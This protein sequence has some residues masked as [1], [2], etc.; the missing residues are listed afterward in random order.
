MARVEVVEFYTDERLRSAIVYMIEAAQVIGVSKLGRTKLMK[1]LF[2]AD[3]RSMQELKR[4]ISGT[5]YTYY[6]YGP[7][8]SDVLLA[9]EEMDGYEILEVPRDFATDTEE[10]L[11]YSYSLGE[12][13]RFE[14]QLPEEDR[15]II[16]EVLI[17]YGGL[18]LSALLKHVYGMTRMKDAEPF[19]MILSD[20]R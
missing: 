12:S 18:S 6:T 17:E 13:P 4:T 3:D 8:A 10:K 5:E 9:L 11:A 14:V 2:L 20:V 15:R 1:L 7:F 19:S 16:K